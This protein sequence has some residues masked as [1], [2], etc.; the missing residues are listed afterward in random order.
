MQEYISEL[1]HKWHLPPYAWNLLLVFG[2]LLLG[3]LISVVLSLFVRKQTTD[4]IRFSYTQSLLRYLT[5][6]FSFLIPLIV[7]NNIIP[8]LRMDKIFR[9]RIEQ[10]TEIALI[11]AFAWLLVRCVRV[12]QDIV[13]HKININQKNNLRQRQIITQLI[14]VR[15]VVV[16]IIILLA[17]GAVLLSFD[18]MRKIGAGLLTSVGIG[19]LIIGFAAQRSLANLLAGFQIAF[20]QPIRIDDEV[21]VENE[22]GRIEELTLTYVVVRIWDNRRLVLPINYFLEKPFQNWTRR[23]AEIL[24]TVFFYV[25]Y[26]IPVDWVRTEFLKLV[27]GHELW[28]RR[29]AGLVVT[30]LKTDVMELRALVSAANSGNAFDLRCFI[31]EQLMKRITETYPQYLPKT[32]AF[33]REEQKDQPSQINEG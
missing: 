9:N 3:L 18:T 12:A 7:F 13:H 29:S 11:I 19:G 27:E 6:P 28:D 10:L 21:V 32:R 22:F 23:S 14:Y 31:R 20:T 24:G 26:G 17:I 33:I 2:S 15:R 25:D 8:L 5:L 4:V 1:L 30:D 16:G